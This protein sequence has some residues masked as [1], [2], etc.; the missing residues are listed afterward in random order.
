M[1]E[2]MTKF[3]SK[4]DRSVTINAVQ[5]HFATSNSH[6]NYYI[7]VTRLKVRAKEAENAAAS[8]RAKLLHQ[9]EDVDTIVCL[10]GTEVLG[11]FLAQELEKG[12]FH[13]TNKHD[14]M[15]IIRPEENSIHQFMFRQNNRLAIE[16]KNILILAA[17]LTTGETMRRMMECVR[18]YGGRVSGVTSI[19]STMREVDGQRIISLFTEDDLPGYAAYHPSECP[20]CAKKV[21]IEAVVNGYGYSTL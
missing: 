4:D 12:S 19:F 10:D 18:Y 2:R 1:Q 16:G 9:V 6:I 13:M 15:Y 11:G 14:T 7:D 21:P 5:G 8:L 20:F 3:Y 17:T